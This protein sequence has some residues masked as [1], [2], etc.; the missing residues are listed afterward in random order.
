VPFLVHVP[1]TF[2]HLAPGEPGSATD[3]L[4]SFVDL[5]PTVLSL[6]GVPIPKHMQGVAF[7]GDQAGEPRQYVYGFRDRMD[8]RYDLIRMVRDDRYLYIRNYHPE[9]PWFHHQFISYMY[10]MPTMQVWQRLADQGQLSGPP[11]T[12]MA[13][14][15]PI[16]ELYDTQNDPHNVHN[17]AD[18]PEHLE[19]LHRLRTALR[20]WQHDII[21]LGLLPEHDLRTRFGDESPYDAVRRDPSS[22]PFSRIA[23]T[24]DRANRRRGKYLGLLLDRLGDDDPAVRYWAATGIGALGDEAGSQPVDLLR[25][26]LDDD[27]PIVR[28]AAADALCR[29]GRTEA[30]VPVLAGILREPGR[31]EW[32]PLAA[33]NVLD[34]ID[35]AAD[36]VVP[37]LDRARQDPNSYVVRVAEHALEPFR[38]AED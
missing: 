18:S 34:R 35:R 21:D 16:E 17:L 6:A 30:A 10:E 38:D 29:L 20:S 28:V 11:A 26:L 7:L 22:Y 32:A 27:S 13:L 3:R 25:S 14:S 19:A 8:E 1:E 33:I 4:I 15:K 2:R 37:V 9:R 12:F 5:A 24:A 36:D 23:E 31:D